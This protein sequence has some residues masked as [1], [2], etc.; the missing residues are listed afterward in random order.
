MLWIRTFRL[1]FLLARFS[2]YFYSLAIFLR[3]LFLLK[4]F[5]F[6]EDS[7]FFGKDIGMEGVGDDSSFTELVVDDTYFI[8]SLGRWYFYTPMLTAF[9]HSFKSFFENSPVSTQY[10]FLVIFLFLETIW[11]HFCVFSSRFSICFFYFTI[12][13]DFILEQNN[14][15]YVTID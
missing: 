12:G 3:R 1:T 9:L 7:P 6:L 11:S 8:F 5:L 10:C 15:T 14:V 2:F 13:K 4:P